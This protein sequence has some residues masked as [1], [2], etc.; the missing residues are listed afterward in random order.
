MDL[1]FYSNT[2]LR[3]SPIARRFITN[4]KTFQSSYEKSARYHVTSL[5]TALPSVQSAQKTGN[6]VFGTFVRNE[7]YCTTFQIQPLSHAECKSNEKVRGRSWYR[8][9]ILSRVLSK[10]LNFKDP[11][12]WLLT[13]GVQ[14]LQTHNPKIK[15]DCLVMTNKKKGLFMVLGD[16]CLSL[17]DFLKLVSSTWFVCSETI[18]SLVSRWASGRRPAVFARSQRRS[19]FSQT[20][21]RGTAAGTV[22]RQ[23]ARVAVYDFLTF[24]LLVLRCRC[25]ALLK[26]KRKKILVLQ[27]HFENCSKYVTLNC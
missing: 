2:H 3:L 4:N 16:P 26:V 20:R 17:V 7:I 13:F 14:F 19:G 15:A 6:C 27:L 10:Y 9:L 24:D 11:T 18:L 25:F 1:P 8:R 22:W 21:S 23:C 5:A 12:F